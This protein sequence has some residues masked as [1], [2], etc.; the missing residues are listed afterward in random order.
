MREGVIT[1]LMDRIIEPLRSQ[2]ERNQQYPIYEEKL[3]AADLDPWELDSRYRFQ[4]VPLLETDELVEALEVDPPLGQFAH[5]DIVRMNLTPNPKMG[6][7][8]IPWTAADVETVK[9]VGETVYGWLDIGADDVLQ[10]AF[11]FAPFV[12]GL[13]TAGVI[14]A[15][16]ATHIPMGPGN[17]EDQ[18]EVLQTYDVSVLRA[19]PSFVMKLADE[20]DEPPE[21]LEVV[22]CGGEPFT[23]IDGYRESVK[24]ALGGVTAVD[25]YGLSEVSIVGREC[26]EENGLHIVND[27]VYAEVVNPETHE[28]LP[29]GERGELVLT[30]LQKE[31]MPVQRYLTGD[32]TTLETIS[33]SCGH[34]GQHLPNGVMG[35]TDDM[36]KVKGV[37]LYPSQ[38]ALHIAG[39]DALDASNVQF[40]LKREGGDTDRVELRIG[41]DTDD[42]P[43]VDQIHESLADELLFSVDEITVT[44]G[45]EVDTAVVDKR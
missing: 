18:V 40:I 13:Q 31:G 7:M 33:C 20:L 24:E 36:H 42:A 27:F 11:S 15:L 12:A 29:K 16:G 22:V 39:F 38:A 2:L 1:S 44:P 23:A 26:Q 37:K 10:N 41:G 25:S 5:E 8:P 6:R 32:L 21:S 34:D 35:R 19:F 30:H 3:A 45:L 28:P 14:E 4:D 43:P 9:S 17:T